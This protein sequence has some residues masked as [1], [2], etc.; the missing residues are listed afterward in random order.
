MF[1]HYLGGGGG[2][3]AARQGSDGGRAAVAVAAEQ[4]RAGYAAA[5]PMSTHARTH[6]WSRDE[7]SNY[8]C[9]QSV[10]HKQTRQAQ[11]TKGVFLVARE[12]RNF[13]KESWAATFNCAPN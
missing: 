9:I 5:E 1:A 11:P 10:M 4:W 3:I 8:I 12:I 6:V 13:R 7:T 2:R